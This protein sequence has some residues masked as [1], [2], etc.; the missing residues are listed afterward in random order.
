MKKVIIVIC[1]MLVLFLTACEKNSMDYSCGDLGGEN[2]SNDYDCREGEFSVKANDSDKYKHCCL[3]NNS[4][5][6]SRLLPK[7]IPECAKKF[8]ERKY[9]RFIEIREDSEA[10][11]QMQNDIDNLRESLHKLEK[12]EEFSYAFETSSGLGAPS[13]NVTFYKTNGVYV[14]EREQYDGTMEEENLTFEE[15]VDK[16]SP[17]N[18]LEKGYKN[19][20]KRCNIDY[21]IE[22]YDRRDEKPGICYRSLNSMASGFGSCYDEELGLIYHKSGGA[23]VFSHSLSRK[24]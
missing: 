23:H 8:P 5:V 16:L 1:V 21:G 13:L 6:R 20:Y 12:S 2:K 3:S 17:L 11:R 24:K 19:L 15:V 10:K 22:K 14:L 9:E 18:E 4:N 7:G